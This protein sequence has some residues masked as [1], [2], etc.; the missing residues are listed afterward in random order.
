MLQVKKNAKREK[1]N[2]KDIVSGRLCGPVSL[3][4]EEK[5]SSLKLT[6]TGVYK[7]TL[8]T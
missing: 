3:R 8:V 5:L 7:R 4:E 2:K 6:L 1:G